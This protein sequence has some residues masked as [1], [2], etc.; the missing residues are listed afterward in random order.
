MW[1]D[2]RMAECLNCGYLK[3]NIFFFQGTSHYYVKG[4]KKCKF[5]INY[6]IPKTKEYKE[7]TKCPICGNKDLIEYQKWTKDKFRECPKCGKK[8]LEFTITGM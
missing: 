1:V 8:K 4:C 3:E 2:M 6:E 7:L 5:I